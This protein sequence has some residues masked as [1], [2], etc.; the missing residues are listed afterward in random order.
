M[1]ALLNYFMLFLIVAFITA[2]NILKKT[3][4]NRFSGGVYLHSATIAF[5]SLLFFAAVNRE[6]SFRVEMLVPAFAF[7]LAFSSA[8]A[9]TVLAVKNGSLANTSLII[10]YSLLIPCFYGVLFLDEP[11]GWTLIVG[12]ALLA[13]SLFLTNYQ[14]SADGEKAITL[15]WVVFAAIAFVGNGM[16]STVQK[17]AGLSFTSGEINMIM[18]LAL[19]M[20][21]IFLLAAS[22][23]SG[24]KKEWRAC[25][26][27]GFVIG[28]ASGLM[29]GA[30]NYFVIYLNPRM[31]ASIMF[32]IISGGGL[33]LVFLYSILISRE[34]FNLQQWI[35]FAVGLVSLVILNI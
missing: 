15:K 24:E 7:A 22:L 27:A 35:G 10:S 29:N 26:K 8:L 9:F 3:Y 18:I 14:K 30:V 33:V 17:A 1:D 13:I 20:V 6:W 19:A 28:L 23:G 25:C 11:I 2:Q 21:V 12:V 34:K 31:S 4:N 5:F 16:C 32:P